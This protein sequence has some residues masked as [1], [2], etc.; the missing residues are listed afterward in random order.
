[1]RDL[2]RIKL[3]LLRRRASSPEEA[4]ERARR[5]A[6][7][8]RAALAAARAGSPPPAELDTPPEVTPAQPVRPVRVEWT[9]CARCYSPHEAP[10]GTVCERC[11]TAMD[12]APADPAF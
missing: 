9:T 3:D 11:K 7:L 6:A 5:G 4:A 8:A 2:D 10:P 12:D 1:M